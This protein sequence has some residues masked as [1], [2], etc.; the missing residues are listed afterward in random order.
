M[1]SENFL[2]FK[3]LYEEYKR[4]SKDFLIDNYK[5]WIGSKKLR[6]DKLEEIS[7]FRLETFFSFL[8]ILRFIYYY[9]DVFKVIKKYNDDAWFAYEILKFLLE[10]KLV[11]IR[12]NKIIFIDSYGDFFIKPISEFGILKKLRESVKRKINL[13]KPLLYNFDPNSKF[14][15]KSKYDQ[16]PITTK[17][18]IFILSRISYYFPA[19]LN[20]AFVGDD[21]FLSVAFNLIFNSNTF[22]IDKDKV[23]ISEIDRICSKIG[24]KVVTL[25]HDIRELKKID[26]FYGCYTNPPYNI[27]GSLKFVKFSTNLLSKDGGTIFLIL[28]NDAIKRR[29]V[30]FQKE[31]SNYG[32]I[33]RELTPSIISYEFNPYH[34][35]DVIIQ[36]KMKSIGIKIDEKETMFAAFYVLEYVGKFRNFKIPVEIYSYV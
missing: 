36:K 22:S 16:I 8:D 30:L 19:R 18:A 7:N 35:E 24:A 6:R 21:D 34:K 25:K 2:F 12:G 31:I 26:T 23:L 32:L 11:K 5:Y 20:F 3:K 28:G 4:F 15:W 1:S 14:K 13:N 33:L 27:S 17:S 29:G 9:G 10:K